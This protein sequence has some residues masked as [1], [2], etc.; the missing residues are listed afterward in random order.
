M[1]IMWMNILS[2]RGPRQALMAHTG[3]YPLFKR[4]P[5]ILQALND[6]H[7]AACCLVLLTVWA[8]WHQPPVWLWNEILH[9][10][11][12]HNGT[13]HQWLCPYIALLSKNPQS[14][15]LLSS[16]LCAPGTTLP[17]AHPAAQGEGGISIQW[18]SLAG[19]QHCSTVRVRSSKC[20]Q[21]LQVG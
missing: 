9:Q 19:L 21:A 4:S 5:V 13:K 10:Q 6:W 20:L 7:V 3:L 15:L 2:G 18:D 14:L 16:K 12:G 1:G 17:Q 8:T 11:K